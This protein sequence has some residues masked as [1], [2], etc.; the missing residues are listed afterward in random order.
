VRNHYAY[1]LATL[2]V[3]AGCAQVLGYDDFGFETPDSGSGGGGGAGGSTDSGLGGMLDASVGGSGGTTGG[4]GGGDASEEEASPPVPCSGEGPAYVHG[5]LWA[6]WHNTHVACNAQ[7]RWL[8]ICQKRLGQGKCPV[9]AQRFQDCWTATGE[10]PETA[11]GGDSTPA[12]HSA[13]LSVCQPHQ[14]PEKNLAS[15]RPSNAVP[16]DTSTFDDDSLRRKDPFFGMDWWASP[17]STRH[18]TLKAFAEGQ[19]PYANQG[20]ADGL[21]VLS[22][23]AFN[24]A[25]FTQ[26]MVNH[27]YPTKVLGGG[28][29]PPLTGSEESAYPSQNFGAFFWLEVPT[30]QPVTL[31]ATWIGP[32]GDTVDPVCS[33]G[34]SIYS[35][36]ESFS[37]HGED[38][39][40]WFISSPCWDVIPS[41]QLEA[42]RHYLWD[43]DGFRLMDDCSGPP[44]ALLELVPS[45]LRESFK[46]GTC[47]SM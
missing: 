21:V 2:V 33:P 41:V 28:C 8:W 43:I 11:W 12:P 31:T 36:P 18:L 39:K 20:Q 34:A 32:V 40:P 22:T 23:H 24:K 46:D 27:S 3:G 9:E 7:H 44:A 16:C 6:F 38:G 45:N 26:G 15:V 37:Y 5:D 4:T 10:F 19:D 17:V 42:G 14:F 30:D 29:L 25:A 13:S 47:S 35:F 1:L